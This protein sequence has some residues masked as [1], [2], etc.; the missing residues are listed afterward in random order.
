[1][2]NP[3]IWEQVQ[4][5]SV[6]D[7]LTAAEAIV[8]NDIKSRM[9]ITL[10]TEGIPPQVCQGMHFKHLWPAELDVY[11]RLKLSENPRIKIGI[12]R[13]SAEVLPYLA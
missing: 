1:M 7:P 3:Q 11:L 2:D 5:G 8:L 13:Q 9:G 4:H 12:L 10:V 6:K